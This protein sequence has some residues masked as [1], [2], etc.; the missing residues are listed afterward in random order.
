MKPKIKVNFF[1]LNWL[2]E[3]KYKKK[4]KKAGTYPKIN[5]GKTSKQQ[6]EN[7]SGAF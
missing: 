1:I 4:N 7:T 5:N 3:N 2:I 6:D